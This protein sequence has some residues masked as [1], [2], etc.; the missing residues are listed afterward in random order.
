MKALLIC[1]IIA[2]SV[3]I[4]FI[5]FLL[6]SLFVNEKKFF[7]KEVQLEKKISYYISV[8]KERSGDTEKK[9][10]DFNSFKKPMT[11]YRGRQR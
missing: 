3:C 5:V 10:F 11:N 9:G 4:V 8:L 7:E 1:S 6:V 2:F